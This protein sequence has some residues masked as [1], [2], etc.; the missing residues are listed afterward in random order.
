MAQ[1][2]LK[3]CGN[4]CVLFDNKTKEKDKKSEQLGQLLSLVDMVVERNGGKPYTDELFVELKVVVQ[5]L[6]LFHRSFMMIF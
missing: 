6:S 2:I 5:L 3:M 4:R 1:E